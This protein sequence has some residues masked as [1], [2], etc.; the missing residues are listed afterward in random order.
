MLA[1]TGAATLSATVTVSATPSTTA[2]EIGSLAQWVATATDSTD[3]GATFTY[4]FSIQSSGYTQFAIFRDFYR[5]NYFDYRP[6]GREGPYDVRVIARSSTGAMGSV[7]EH[8]LTV[9]RVTGSSPVISGTGHPLVPIYSAPPCAPPG[10][11]RVRFKSASDATWQWT[12]FKGCTGASLNFYIAGMKPSTA[13]SVQQQNPDNSFGP[14]LTF[15]TGSIPGD[16]TIPNHFILKSAESPTSSTYPILF[17]AGIP[18]AFATDLNGNVIWYL[19]AYTPGET[20]YTTRVFPGGYFTGSMDDRTTNCP[21]TTR[22]CGDHRFFREFDLGGH[23]IRE[24][25]FTALNIH[26]NAWRKAEGKTPV[27]LTFFSHEGTQLP[28]GDIATIVT[29]ERVADQGQGPVDVLGDTVVVFD[30]NF[31]LKWF[32]DGFDFL[33]IKRKALKDDL[34]TQG[35]GGCPILFNRQSNGEYYTVANDWTHAN[36]ISYDPKDGNLLVSLRHQA[37]VIKIAYQN[38]AGDGHVIWRLGPQGDF[39]L[40]PGAVADEWFNYQ[41][42]ANVQ[43]NGLLTLFDN[44]NLYSGDSRGQAWKLDETN[45]IATPIANADLGVRS[46]ALG[47]AAPLSNGNYM[48]GAGFIDGNHGQAIEMTPSPSY[49]VVFK[50]QTDQF[51]YRYFRMS[52]MYSVQ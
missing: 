40:S 14:V 18:S 28:N 26:V 4:Q 10:A 51:V 22:H 36:S 49:R 31:N 47:S 8:G 44:N 9:S 7:I 52:S 1:S 25:N 45:L 20:G 35:G 16:V 39:A 43:A 13:Y 29:D 34:C 30:S 6:A 5:Y 15:T 2:V 11:I 21:G 32:W 24:T 38:A 3:P 41:H 12:S 37:W 17:H 42:D 23:I 50:E 46:T 27:H 19:P 48:F 33:D